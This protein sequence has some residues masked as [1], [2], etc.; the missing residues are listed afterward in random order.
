[1]YQRLACL[2]PVRG[3]RMTKDD[4]GGA[5]SSMPV[6]CTPA[7]VLSISASRP[8]Y[9]VD[10]PQCCGRV[11]PPCL[12]LVRRR[13]I[14]RGWRFVVTTSVLV[15]GAMCYLMGI[16]GYLL[17]GPATEGDI[18]D[19]FAG[20]WVATILKCCVAGHLVCYIPGEVRKASIYSRPS[21]L[22]DQDLHPSDA[23]RNKTWFCSMRIS[24]KQRFRFVSSSPKY[25]RSVFQFSRVVVCCLR[26]LSP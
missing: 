10:S 6:C 4:E 20:G 14:N 13:H 18:L 26:K 9:F 2:M 17:F 11:T 16:F 23:T 15:G 3:P 25:F 5:S 1:M 7:C 21:P 12:P 24:C 19:N 22:V 8:Y